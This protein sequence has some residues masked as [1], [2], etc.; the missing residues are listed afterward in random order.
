[1]NNYEAWLQLEEELIG[2]YCQKTLKRMV[3]VTL[4]LVIVI[5]AVVFGILG[6]IGEGK[7]QAALEGALSGAVFG[8]IISAIMLLFSLLNL[9]ASKYVNQ[10]KKSVDEL[11]IADWEKD[12]LGQEMLEAYRA[13]KQT[14]FY[15]ISAP[16]QGNS[17]PA[18]F[19]LTPHYC[20]LVGSSPYC[21]LVRFSDVERMG[22]S[23]E[24][25]V[26]TRRG[27]KSKTTYYFSLYCIDFYGKNGEDTPFTAMG[28]LEP[29]LREKV[30]SML[31]GA[32]IKISD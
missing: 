3:C 14:I 27:G 13:K 11:G 30:L 32:V 28:F 24:K 17:T 21:I 10:I 25:K 22:T 8:A 29:E 4:P 6:F 19:M 18:H 20:V 2:A 9:R 7:A 23:I 5:M 12:E 26:A 16:G 15:D 31:E 1:M